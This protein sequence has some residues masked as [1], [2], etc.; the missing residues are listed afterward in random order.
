[1]TTTESRTEQISQSETSQHPEKYV[2]N[3]FNRHGKIELCR[4]IFAAANIPYK[5]NY[6][7]NLTDSGKIIRLITRCLIL[8]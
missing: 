3:Y 1:M 2:L 8:S 6:S 5:D 7:K 4:L